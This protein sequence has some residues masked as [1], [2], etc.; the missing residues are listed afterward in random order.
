MSQSDGRIFLGSGNP[1]DQIDDL[2]PPPPW[3]DFGRDAR[4][5][6]GKTYL[7]GKREVE[8]VNAA[9][10][11]RRP[12]L[13]T[14]RPGVGK[15]SLA[16]AVAWELK[17]GEVLTWP[18]NTRSTLQQGLYDYDAIGRVRDAS[19]QSG[20]DQRE[21]DGEGTILD[22]G[23]YIRLGPLGT[24]LL[25]GE[26]GRPRV[27]LID[28]ID[29]GDVDLPNDLLNA[30]EEGEFEIRELARAGANREAVVSTH[31]RVKAKVVGGKVSCNVFPLVFLTSNGER[32]FPPAF[33][34]RCLRLDID[35]PGE[36]ELT[37]IV[38]S[39]LSAEPRY[40]AAVTGLIAEFVK[41]RDKQSK[42]L[43]TDQLLN[44]IF[45]TVQGID[46]TA[47]ETLHEAV[48]RALDEGN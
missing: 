41:Q 25:G 1:H 18:I 45:L 14:G 26:S 35:P 8:L 2:P 4:A 20:L 32:E 46:L 24:A 47:R 9:L 29:K 31:D 21:R 17:L 6:K 34:R 27:V 28:E 22:M 15:T 23:S 30:F 37:A 33:L 16:H 43:A 48:M 39:H 7:A 3:R 36:G 44:A 11:L 40:E 12:L 19:V 38:R 5:H 13:I 10:Y 42:M